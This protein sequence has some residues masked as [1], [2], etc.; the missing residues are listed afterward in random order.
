MVGL[1]VHSNL[2][3][4]E[5]N[6][7]TDR[8]RKGSALLCPFYLQIKFCFFS[9]READSNELHCFMFA[10]YS[11]LQRFCSCFLV[12]LLSVMPASV[13]GIF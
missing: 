13:T 10:F 2:N 3:L 11:I 9:L 5:K 8:L 12:L 6:S 7:F 4:V 1:K